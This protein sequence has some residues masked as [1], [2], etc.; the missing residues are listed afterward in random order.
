MS[1]FRVALFAVATHVA[2]LSQVIEAFVPSFR[3]FH[4]SLVKARASDADF[5]RP[6]M[7]SRNMIIDP[8]LRKAVITFRISSSLAV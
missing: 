5:T 6:W 4:C 3:S 7:L 1:V 8:S 2:R